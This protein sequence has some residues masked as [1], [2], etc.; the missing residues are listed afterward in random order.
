MCLQNQPQH[1]KFGEA[2]WLG[3]EPP[4][5]RVGGLCIFSS[6]HPA[7]SFTP[8]RCSSEAYDGPRSKTVSQHRSEIYVHKASAVGSVLVWAGQLPS[9]LWP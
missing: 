8:S 4:R 2:P 1:M 9:L 7:Q 3:F 6:S 5:A